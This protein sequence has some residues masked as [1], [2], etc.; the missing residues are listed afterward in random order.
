METQNENNYV[1]PKVK[2]VE[3][4]SWCIICTSPGA[5]SGAD[6]SGNNDGYDGFQDE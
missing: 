2:I 6:G 3:L 1:A 5:D 4:Q